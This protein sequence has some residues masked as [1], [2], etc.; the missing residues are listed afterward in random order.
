MKTVFVA[1]SGGID[2]SFSAYLLKKAGHRVV[3]FTFDL[4]PNSMRNERNR[5]TC[6]SAATINK[7]KQIADRLSI[8]HY[9]V[10]A[11]GEF[12]EH[13]I[14]KFIEEY[15]Q[16]RT[17]NP[18]ILCNRYI[19]FSAFL[20]RSLA[21]GAD[22]VATGHY[23]R[24]EETPDGPVLKKGRDI[25]KDQSYFLYPI[26]RDSLPLIE[27]PIGD[28][29][30]TEVKAEFAR[31]SP[32]QTAESQ[33]ICFIPDNDYRSFIGRFLPLRKGPIVMTDGRRLGT[34]DGVHLYTIGQRRG[35]NIPFREP[36]YVVGIDAAENVVVVGSKEELK[37]DRVIANDL[38]LLTTE[39]EGEARAKVRYRQKEE[40]CS[41]R[42]AD[43]TME[44]V[45]DDPVSSVTPGQSIVL[46]RGE[47]VL[48]GGVIRRA[49]VGGQKSEVGKIKKN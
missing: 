28:Y 1:M 31:Y 11:R 14:H 26:R 21:M 9:V 43:D 15:R 42:I 33:D 39:R 46:Y 40:K 45:F 6:C 5:K 2:S 22:R 38:N 36:L 4:L 32:T 18:C 23:A 29:R 41:Y 27:F 30:K 10:N 25:S 20:T 12:E 47:T 13:V 17:P 24:I 3:G 49:E 48:G 34:H 44:V 16:G 7:A 8:P 37:Q 19:K 35:L